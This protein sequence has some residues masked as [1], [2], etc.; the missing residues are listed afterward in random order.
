MSP[1][2]SPPVPPI[3][4]DA[5]SISSRCPLRRKSGAHR[6]E[7]GPLLLTY[8]FSATG[9]RRAGTAWMRSAFIDVSPLGWIPLH[10]LH[11][12]PSSPAGFRSTL[13]RLPLV[14][15]CFCIDL[16]FTTRQLPQPT[17]INA[18]ECPAE[19]KSS[20]IRGGQHL[21][22][23]PVQVNVDFRAY[24]RMVGFRLTY[25]RYNEDRQPCRS[26]HSSCPRRRRFS[27][28][29]AGAHEGRPG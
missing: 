23:R 9:Q 4:L 27:R 26:S 12:L 5:R 15:C 2:F 17:R 14:V 13:D 21:T 10:H 22:L 7:I 3:K 29:S 8:S 25:E 28:L 24:Q 16:T 18:A 1:A 20:Q 11:R 6:L 19:V